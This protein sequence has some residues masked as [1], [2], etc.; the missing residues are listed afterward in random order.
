VVIPLTIIKKL[1]QKTSPMAQFTA[2]L[3][4]NWLLFSRNWLGSLLEIIVPLWFAIILGVFANLAETT[5]KSNWSYLLKSNYTTN[6]YPTSFT[7]WADAFKP[8]ASQPW[9]KDCGV[10]KE[11]DQT[12]YRRGGKV[13]LAPDNTLTRAIGAQLK[14]TGLVP[15]Y[16]SS[17]AE[18]NRLIKKDEIYGTLDQATNMKW[19]FCFAISFEEQSST[20]YTYNIRY[21]NTGPGMIDD[22]WDPLDAQYV[23]YK[24]EDLGVW[25][26]H[27]DSGMPGVISL[28]DNFILQ[29]ALSVTNSATPTAYIKPTITNMPIKKAKQSNLFEVTGGRLVAFFLFLPLLLPYLRTVYYMLYE[30]NIKVIDNLKNQGM[31]STLN[32]LSWITF[33]F[34]QIFAMSLIW[35]LIIKTMFWKNQNFFNIWMVFLMTGWFMIAMAVFIQTMFMGTKNGTFAALVIGMIFFN[36]SLAL[37]TAGDIDA[38]TSYKFAISPIA[39]VQLASKVLIVYEQE[40]RTLPTADWFK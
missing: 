28:V 17:D 5:D 25:K 32:H 11:L 18:M 24:V 38:S 2:L 9:I 40:F 34:S 14:L 23:L 20:K 1:I 39:G 29:D 27:R 3:Y 22:V 7:N 19:Q 21:N 37:E 6:L 8:T 36:S 33:K 10:L 4:K 35:T 16:V 31:S 30:K 15:W 12:M 13:G 26:Q